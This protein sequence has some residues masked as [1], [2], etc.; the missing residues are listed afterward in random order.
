MFKLKEVKKQEESGRKARA[1]RNL[2]LN[3]RFFSAVKWDVVQ[4]SKFM[5]LTSLSRL[6]FCKVQFFSVCE[7][8]SEID[9]R[10]KIWFWEFGF[11]R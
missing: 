6:F 4:K 3:L 11:L 2:N 8:I 5:Y 9:A 10:A 7:K 1:D